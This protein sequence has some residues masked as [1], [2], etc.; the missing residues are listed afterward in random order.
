MVS[1]KRMIKKNKLLFII[2]LI[3]TLV[4]YICLNNVI[5]CF[6]NLQESLT[7]YS[8]D[9][10]SF[11]IEGAVNN[12]SMKNIIDSVANEKSFIEFNMKEKMEEEYMVS[13]MFRG[14]YSQ[15]KIPLKDGRLFSLEDY[16]KHNFTMIVKDNVY[17]SLKE[18]N[19][20]NVSDGKEYIDYC[21]DKYEI[22]GIIDSDKANSYSDIYI[23]IYSAIDN[24]KIID[25]VSSYCFIY[26]CGKDTKSNLKRM[27][28]MYQNIQI[29]I[30]DIVNEQN[31]IVSSI[32]F[33]RIY[34]FAMILIMIISFITITNISTYWIREKTKE[35][36]VR[37]LVGAHNSSLAIM[38]MNTYLTVCILGMISG[39][40]IFEVLKRE[41]I[42][43][44]FI[45]YET[46]FSDDLIIFLVSLI[47][48]ILFSLLI[49]IKP[50]VKV[51]KLQ[52]NEVIR[53]E[54]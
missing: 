43:K 30:T 38:T 39:G 24:K 28:D 48:L 47:I 35:L 20:I 13:S 2:F 15:M 44:L 37:K 18:Q 52:I 53:G 54:D 22:I 19:L 42:L 26:D 21:G 32:D 16:K 41:G 46:K 9:T 10:V 4:I 17:D 36:A 34:V 33:N 1:I 7:N 51:C 40:I 27:S 5:G 8:Q 6:I 14:E 11:E 45:N 29:K 23:N 31:P 25:T 3:I 50:I 49:L 12:I